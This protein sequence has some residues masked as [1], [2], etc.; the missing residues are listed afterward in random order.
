MLDEEYSCNDLVKFYCNVKLE[1]KPKRR[2][3]TVPMVFIVALTFNVV[4]TNLFFR[5]TE[6]YPIYIEAIAIG[7]MTLL[8]LT[9]LKGP[10]K[11]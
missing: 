10:E 5:F 2:K 4:I 11:G 6:W 9:L 8:Y 7:C 3:L 1:Y